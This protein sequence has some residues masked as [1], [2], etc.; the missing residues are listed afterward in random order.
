VTHLAKIPVKR[1]APRSLTEYV[2][3]IQN[4]ST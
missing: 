4:V 1:Q 2:T 3:V